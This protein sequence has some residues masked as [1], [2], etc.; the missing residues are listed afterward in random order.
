[1]DF[2]GVGIV[3]G[4]KNGEFFSPFSAPFGGFFCSQK[5]PSL[6]LVEKASEKFYEWL[7]EKNKKCHITFPPFIYG[8]TLIS[9]SFFCL[10]NKGFTVEYTD[11]NYSIDLTKTLQPHP[12]FCKNLRAA[13]KESLVFKKCEDNA[14]RKDAYEI[15]NKNRKERGY[16]P[17]LS[18]EELQEVRNIC[19]ID[20]FLVCLNEIPIAGAFIYLTTSDIAQLI[21]WGDN[22]EYSKTRPMNLLAMRIAEHYKERDFSHFDLGPASKA[23]IPNFGLSRFKS[24]MGCEITLKHTVAL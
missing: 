20:C 11:L 4:E 14:E 1:L 18:F 2:G 21:L 5:K 6:E 16:P 17:H 13:L 23:G 22:R 3:L 12:N 24:E 10:Q 9:Q 8:E 15:I 19:E 7:K